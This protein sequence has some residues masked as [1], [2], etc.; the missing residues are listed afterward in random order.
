MLCALHVTSVH[1]TNMHATSAHTL[2]M[3]YVC[4]SACSVFA[5]SQSAQQ[6]QTLIIMPMAVAGV[7]A[8]ERWCIVAV[9]GVVAGK[10]LPLQLRS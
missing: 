8:W 9:A 1:A 2:S 4:S 6:D 5:L 10:C 3:I 7:V